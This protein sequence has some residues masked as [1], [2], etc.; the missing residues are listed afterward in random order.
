MNP[1]AEKA[2]QALP[3]PV[4]DTIASG[5]DRLQG[6]TPPSPPV[7][8]LSRPFR[9]LVG[10]VNYAGQGYRWSRAVETSGVVSARNYVHEAN[11]PF[12][13]GADHLVSW[14]TAEHSRQWQKEMLREIRESYTHVLI[15]ACFPILGGMVHGDVRRQV[16]LIQDAGVRVGMVGHGNEVRL[17]SRHRAESPWSQFHN[18]DEWVAAELVE[19]VVASNLALIDDLQIPTFV[20]TAGLLADLPEA[21]FLGVVIDPERWSNANPLLTEKRIRVVHAPTN[22]FIKGTPLIAPIVQSLVDDG[23]IEY[24]EIKNLANEE[25]QEVFAHADVILDQFRI[26]DYGVGACEAMASGRVVLTYVDD[27]VRAE[28]ERHAKM[29]LPIPAVTVATL[30]ATIRE[31]AAERERYRALA[32]SGP[33]FVRRLHNGDFSRDVLLRDLIQR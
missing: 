17:P 30:D 2:W 24:T 32:D 4:Q 22:P 18:S 5:I 13:Y 21:A 1:V 23:I 33:E 9:L 20:S 28:V 3:K 11:N 8:D 16:A 31:I 26:G 10:P 27:Q 14:R 29:P 7:P 6:I 25:M 12:Q 15:E 19:D